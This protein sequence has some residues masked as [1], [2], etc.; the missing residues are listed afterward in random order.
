MS[1]THV[2]ATLCGASNK[3]MRVIHAMWNHSALCR[4]SVSL[5]AAGT[6]E[7]S[8]PSLL[9]RSADF[10]RNGCMESPSWNEVNHQLRKTDSDRYTVLLLD[11]R[12]RT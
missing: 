2:G 12:E 5:W 7:T 10:I 9:S 11:A 4:R 1:N 3:H 6:G 8:P